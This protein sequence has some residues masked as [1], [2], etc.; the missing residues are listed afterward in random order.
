MRTFDLS[1][2]LQSA[3]G[4]DDMFGLDQN[5]LEDRQKEPSYPHYNIEKTGED[6]YL[7]SMALAGFSQEDLSITVEGDTLFIEDKVA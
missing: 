7:I 2:L 1:P 5:G 3:I 6:Q 4:F